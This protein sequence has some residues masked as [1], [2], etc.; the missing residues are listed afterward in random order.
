MISQA[1]FDLR[2]LLGFILVGGSGELALAGGLF[3]NG[4]LPAAV[5]A[6]L[7]LAGFALLLHRSFFRFSVLI[8]LRGN[9]PKVLAA[10]P[11]FLQHKWEEV[12]TRDT[13]PEC[14]CAKVAECLEE[15]PFLHLGGVFN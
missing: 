9:I 7:E 3:H 4:V 8:A 1:V 12:P 10:G 15:T 11:A 2:Q 14:S 5:V 13:K 6:F